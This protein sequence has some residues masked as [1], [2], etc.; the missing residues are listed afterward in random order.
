MKTKA[1]R[2]ALVAVVLILAA[3]AAAHADAT[4]VFYAATTASTFDRPSSLSTLRGELVHYASRIPFF[5]NANATCSF[6][7]TQEGDDFDGVL[8]IY[9]NGFNPASPLTNLIAINDDFST[10]DGGLGIGTSAVERINL[11]FVN[12]YY[13]VLA[14][15]NAS[16]AGTATITISCSDPAT[17]VIAGDGVLPSYNGRYAELLNGRFRVSATW[18]NFSNVSGNATFVPLGSNDSA[19]M[20]FFAPQNFEVLIKAVNACS[21]NSR[22]WIFYAATTNVEFTIDVYDTVL[23]VHNFYHNNLGS[24]SHIA[25]TDTDA[26]PCF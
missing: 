6:Y 5:P 1:F 21:F 20:W 23:D 13:I 2:S 19:I 10:T 24:T 11:Q 14:G 17:R 16:D 15:Y 8:L 12:N 18:T 3:S 4:Q 22:Y 9:R 26:F 7:V 25:E